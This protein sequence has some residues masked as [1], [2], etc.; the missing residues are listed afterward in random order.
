MSPVDHRQTQGQTNDFSQDFSTGRDPFLHYNPYQ[1]AWVPPA[2]VNG[3]PE[4][5]RE[6]TIPQAIPPPVGSVTGPSRVQDLHHFDVAYQG[7]APQPIVANPAYVFPNAGHAQGIPAQTRP[8]ASVNLERNPF[9]H[10]PQHNAPDPVQAAFSHPF[11]HRIPTP[12][13]AGA[14]NLRQLASRY[15][16]HPDAQVDMVSMEAGA[17]GRFKIV[18]ILRLHDVL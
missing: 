18:I 17:V 14:E 9:G 15:L 1:H 6:D 7:V 13:Q 11:V 5:N 12:T 2:P 16:Q 3:Q 10:V 8:N 4:G